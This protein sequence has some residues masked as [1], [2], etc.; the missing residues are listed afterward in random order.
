M[1]KVILLSLAAVAFAGC[2]QESMMDQSIADRADK[3]KFSVYTNLNNAATK[4]V[5]ID[6]VQ[7]LAANGGFKLSAFNGE[8]IYFKDNAITGT[9]VPAPVWTAAQPMYWPTGANLFFNA[10]YPVAPVTGMTNLLNDLEGIRFTYATPN[11]YPLTGDAATV[12]TEQ[13]DIMYAMNHGTYTVGGTPVF[14]GVNKDTNSG[15]VA[16]KFQHALTQIAFKAMVTS[17]GIQVTVSKIELYNVNGIG[18]FT[19][20]T[21]TTADELFSC[22]WTGQTD[23]KRFVAYTS[24]TGTSISN[25]ATATDL[26]SA[27]AAEKLMLIPQVLTKWDNTTIGASATTGAYLKINC[28]IQLLNNS[29]I[30][31]GDIYVP[32]STQNTVDMAEVWMAGNKVTYTLNFGGGFDEGGEPI[33]TPMTYTVEVE[34]WKEENGVNDTDKVN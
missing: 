13:A 19:T 34:K 32:F 15:A 17:P 11:S 5:S 30:H 33:L 12:G 31:K 10:L 25:T 4:G 14:A 9:N 7:A 20:V 16:L 21:P 28:H 24:A 27:E 8:S 26:V 23:L 22:A 3:M 6:D 18:E 29:T 2:S 1:N